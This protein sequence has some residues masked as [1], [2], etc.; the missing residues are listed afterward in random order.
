[1]LLYF[2]KDTKCYGVQVKKEVAEDPDESVKETGGERTELEAGEELVH[3][4]YAPT[5]TQERTSTCTQTDKHAHLKGS[6][7]DEIF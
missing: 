4:T 5:H 3:H 1:V 7:S 2:K 6:N